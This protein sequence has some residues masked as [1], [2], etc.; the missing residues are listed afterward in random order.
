MTLS[1]ELPGQTLAD[2][3]DWSRSLLELRSEYSSLRNHFL[4]YVNHP[5]CLTA[6]SSDP[7]A[8]DPDSPWNTLRRDEAL[9]A[10][11]LQDVQRLPEVPFYHEPRTQTLILDALFVYCK[12]NPDIGGYRQGMHELLAPIVYVLEQDAIDPVGATPDASA[13]LTMV[14]M[15]DASFIE[16]DAFALFSKVMDHAKSFYEVGDAPSKNLSSTPSLGRESSTSSIVEKSQHIHEVCLRRVDPELSDHLKNIEVLPQIFLIRWI[17]LL[18]SREFPFDQI[19][20]LWDT[21]FAID[22]TLQLIDLVCTAMLIRVRWELLEAD[23]SVALQ[24]LLKYPHPQPPHGPHSF[25][26]DAIYL[27]DHLNASGGSA[28]ITK[29]TGRSPAS[30]VGRSRPT[31]PSSWNSSIRRKGPGGRSPLS[32]S[33]LISP[34]VGVEALFQGAAKGVLERGERLGINQAVRDAMVEIRRNVTEAKSSMK[35]NRELFS[36]PRPDTA[37]RAVAGVERRNK[38]LASMLE[39]TISR[40]KTLTTSAIE[41]E[42]KHREELEITTAKIQLV[43][44]YLED[45]TMALPEEPSPSIQATAVGHDENTNSSEPLSDAVAA[46]DLSKPKNDDGPSAPP[47]TL[48]AAEP[49]DRLQANTDAAVDVDPLGLGTTTP[50]QILQRPKPAI[51]TRSSLAQSSFSWMLEP[52]ESSSSQASAP[53]TKPSDQHRKRPS[54]NANRERTAFLFGEVQSDENGQPILPNDT[55]GLEPIGK[56]K[57]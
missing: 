44:I 18:F 21:L 12:L 40:L 38:Q 4:K 25:V 20:T 46:M 6:A 37:I 35:A 11:I 45:S 30:G 32:P 51:P 34:P 55:F 36:E 33:R 28:L 53:R 19:L 41:D 5:E 48:D 23:Y 1:L 24:L 54:A 50:I 17:R 15:L 2:I 31:T 52:D 47:P 43:K 8:D 22:P 7:L 3:D 27:R 56:S 9:R 29:Y 26:D 39:E 14:E 42:Q 49:V 10:E 13:D 57:S 16:H